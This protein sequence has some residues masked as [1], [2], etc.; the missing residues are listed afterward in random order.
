MFCEKPLSVDLRHAGDLAGLVTS[1]GVVNMT[2][3]VLRSSPA[4]LAAR[5]LVRDPASG[6][7]MN[8]VFRDD[9]YLPTQG[10]YGS[11]W[12]GDPDVAGSG[13][14]MEHSIHDVDLAGVVGRTDRVRL[15]AAVVVPRHRGDRGLRQRRSH[16]SRTERPRRWSRCGTTSCRGRANAGS[17][18]SA[19]T[20]W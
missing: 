8:V 4:M 19:S 13:V 3:L 12:R 10:M 6:R 17:R 1:A 16:G 2:G 18:S 20:R 7:V 11:T 14:L 5:E 9:Q 15:G